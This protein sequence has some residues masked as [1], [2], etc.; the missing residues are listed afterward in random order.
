MNKAEAIAAMVNDDAKV[1]HKYFT[2]SEWMTM[3]NGRI[4]FED[5][6]TCEPE[7][8]WRTRT[9]VVWEYDWDTRT[10]ETK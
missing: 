4:L 3:Q 8:F 9:D 6:C 2:D 7:E 5:G 10:Q 1:Y